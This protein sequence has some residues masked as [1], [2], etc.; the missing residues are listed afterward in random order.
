MKIIINKCYGGFG[1]SNKAMKA[2]LA[3]K[4][5]EFISKKGTFGR[6][7]YYTDGSRIHL[8]K[9]FESEIALRTDPDLVEVVTKLGEKSWG[10]HAELAIIDIPDG[11][12]VEIEEYDGYEHIAE[13]HRKWY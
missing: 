5:T 1:I 7:F 10:N 2:L 4:D 13:V 11:I 3:L 6:E 9:M 12:Q 8:H